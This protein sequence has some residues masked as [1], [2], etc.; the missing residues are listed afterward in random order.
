MNATDRRPGSGVV[1]P[2][3]RAFSVAP[4][5][6]YTDRHYRYFARTL[7]RHAL[8]YTEMVTAAA[9]RHG[10]RAH[11]LDYSPQEHP[12]ALQLGGSDPADLAAAARLGEAW[13]YDEINLNLGC[14]SDRVQSGQFG[15]CLMAEPVRVANCLEAMIE[16]VQVP[17]TAKV[18]IGINDRDDY[19]YFRDFVCRLA[20]SGCDT[21]I[22]H[23]RKAVL[24]GLSPKQNREVP[25]LRYDYVHRL[26]RECPDLTLVLNG[27]LRTPQQAS[28]E[29]GALAGVMVGRAACDDP[30]GT[31]S[32]VDA[33]WYGSEAPVLDQHEVL[34][35]M[36]PYVESCCVAGVSFYAVVRHLL[37]LFKGLPGARS[38]RRC[39][40]ENGPKP[41]AGPELLQQAA[42]LIHDEVLADP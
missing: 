33:R 23:A 20:E 1:A 22:V 13:G 2:L 27:G 24:G 37:P 25:P 36:L 28:S 16:A 39:L 30:Y 18:R 8:L 31:L 19:G 10:D 9:L 42:E 34:E 41:G 17:V 3:D 32:G 38:W 14:P 11:L 35:R 5:M 12:L 7:S 29:Q 40:S 21:F 26:Q 4:M 15:A 6:Q